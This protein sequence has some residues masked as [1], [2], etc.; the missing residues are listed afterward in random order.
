M[1][2]TSGAIKFT[3]SYW[4]VRKNWVW[5]EKEENRYKNSDS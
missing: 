2:E 5:D 1:I 4:W 3:V